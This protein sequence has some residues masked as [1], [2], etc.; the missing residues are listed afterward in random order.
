MAH[1][2]FHS[3]ARLTA[4]IRHQKHQR[5]LVKQQNSLLS[6]Q[7]GVLLGGSIVIIISVPMFLTLWIHIIADRFG[8]LF[9]QNSNQRYICPVVRIVS[10]TTGKSVHAGTHTI[11]Q[12]P[13]VCICNNTLK[14]L[15]KLV[16]LGDGEGV[17]TRPIEAENELRILDIW[18]TFVHEVFH[19]C[20]KTGIKIIGN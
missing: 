10:S 6:K 3:I 18:P 12:N 20:C 15:H 19:I 5:V 13:G 17:L 8:I 1:G 16:G 11:G 4:I 2:S 9:G 14:I 7:F